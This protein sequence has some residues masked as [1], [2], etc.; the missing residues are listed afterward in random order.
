MNFQALH[1]YLTFLWVPDPLTMFE[2]IYKLPAGHLAV[3]S[4]GELR[5]SQDRDLRFPRAGTAFQTDAEALALELRERFKASVRSQMLSDVPLG[6]FLSAGLDS[7]SI[8]AAMAEASPR[9]VR[10][11]TIGFAECYRKGELTLDDVTVARRTAKHFGCEHTEILVE[12][13]VV[14]LLP[15]LVWHMDEPVSDPALIAAYLV[16]R[17][18]R[19]TVTVLLSG[20]GGDEL[21][22]GY[23]KYRAHYL[24]AYYRQ[25]PGVL[26]RALVEPVIGGLP[27]FRGTPLK[28]Y[29]RLAKKMVRSGS[30]PPRDRFLT[31]S[32][33]LSD[34][35]KD[36]LY[37]TRSAFA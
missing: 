25:I 23:R 36:H 22:A 21:F 30:L 27:S 24:A 17:E 20:I 9:P 10:T 32:V 14:D 7:S 18:A 13:K 15:K 5:I 19:K 3:F 16:S 34:A 12:P 2:G 31:D 37:P 1:Q 33:Y 4:K 11:Y 35:Q 26:R 29:V 6:A 28:G 8:V